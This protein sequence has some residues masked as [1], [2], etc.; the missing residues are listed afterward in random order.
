MP[1]RFRYRPPMLFNIHKSLTEYRME[2]VKAFIDHSQSGMQTMLE[3]F[4]AEFDR[5]TSGWSQELI[6]DY[7]DHIYDDI[8]MIRDESPE[9]LRH[10]QCMIIYGTFE[11]AIV[12]L[13]RAIHRDQKAPAPSKRIAYM[14]DVRGYLKPLV[15]SSAFGSEWQWMHEL[16]IIRNWM[17]HNGGKA[18]VDSQP[19]GNWMKAKTFRRRNHGLIAFSHHGDI[20]ITNA[21]VDRA[22]E[23]ATAAIAKLHKAVGRR[24]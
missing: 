4:S 11:H 9:L 8:A 13:C 7:A 15:K 10:A 17:A 2:A 21:F 5:T 14:D 1:S 23:K 3:E 6:N 24:Y 18:Q 20:T 22:H 16:R 19:G 12:N